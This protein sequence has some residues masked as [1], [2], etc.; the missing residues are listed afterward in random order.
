MNELGTIRDDGTTSP[1]SRTDAVRARTALAA[2]GGEA[3][4]RELTLTSDD[5]SVTVVIDLA[6]QLLAVAV[7]PSARTHTRVLS[8][9]LLETI[10]SARDRSAKAAIDAARAAG[11]TSEPADTGEE[12][13]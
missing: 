7:D 6:G 8:R 4:A 9:H 12:R 11:L 3:L 2:A 10:N 5:E 1:A 13:P